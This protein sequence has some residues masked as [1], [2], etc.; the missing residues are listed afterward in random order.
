MLPQP[1]LICTCAHIFDLPTT[2]HN[3]RV[4]V[5]ASVQAKLSTCTLEAVYQ[6]SLRVNKSKTVYLT[7]PFSLLLLTVFPRTENDNSI[8]PCILAQNLNHSRFL[9]FSYTQNEICLQILSVLWS[10]YVYYSI[11]FY[12]PLCPNNHFL[13]PTCTLLPHSTPQSLLN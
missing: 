12:Y 10:K 6:P 7:C 13:L 4:N 2:S 11:I 1:P 5:W 3:Y 8:S 9:S